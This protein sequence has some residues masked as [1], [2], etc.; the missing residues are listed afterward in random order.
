V[1][2]SGTRSTRS[3]KSAHNTW[4]EAPTDAVANEPEDGGDVVPKN[5]RHEEAAVDESR[6]AEDLV[7]L[8]SQ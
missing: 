5:D 1:F 3:D 8:S 2:V 6:A 4:I 7:I